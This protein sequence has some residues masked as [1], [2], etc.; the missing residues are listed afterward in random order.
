MTMFR[1]LALAAAVIL[2]AGAAPQAWAG[3]P[4]DQLKAQIDR[5]L[6]V[7]EAP[8]YKPESK[9]RERRAAIRQIAN[10]IFD[11]SE[12]ARRSLARHWQSRT[13]A[14]RQEFVAL[15]ADLLERSYISKIE[16]YGGDRISYQGDVVD[17]DVAFV[18]TKLTTKQGTDIPIEYRM[19]RR[20][21]RWMV[22]DVVIEGISLIANY[23]AQFNKIIQTSSYQELVQRMKTKQEEF[24]AT[25]S[26]EQKRT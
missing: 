3:V 25:H 23:R 21:D 13:P 12:T 14:E 18:R 1:R 17:D 9:H 15:F 22:Y 26:G 4:S 6:R 2:L 8:E 16:L 7:M 24:E 20:G 10:E 11:F 5:V 19:L